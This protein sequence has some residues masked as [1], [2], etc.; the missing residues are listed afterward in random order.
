[1]YLLLWLSL[2]RGKVTPIIRTSLSDQHCHIVTNAGHVSTADVCQAV[3]AVITASLDGQPRCL[4]ADHGGRP[5]KG[6]S[7]WP[8]PWSSRLPFRSSLSSLLPTICLHPCLTEMFVSHFKELSSTVLIR[9]HTAGEG[10]RG[11]VRTMSYLDREG[12]GR[13]RGGRE[14]GGGRGEGGGRAGREL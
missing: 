12:E 2:I 6:V 9:T 1:M 14:E 11:Q 10:A 5:T 8:T 4:P 13:E 3:C 7:R